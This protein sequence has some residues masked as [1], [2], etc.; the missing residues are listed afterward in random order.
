MK[1][2][3]KVRYSLPRWQYTLRLKSSCCSA[4]LVKNLQLQ[5]LAELKQWRKHRSAPASFCYCNVCQKRLLATEGLCYTWV[6]WESEPHAGWPPTPV[7]ILQNWHSFWAAGSSLQ[8]LAKAIEQ[9]QAFEDLTELCHARKPQAKS[10][11]VFSKSFD[12]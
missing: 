2:Q 10:F 9:Q 12:N 7:K 8:Q 11:K 4:D 6:D 1:V 3:L 5:N